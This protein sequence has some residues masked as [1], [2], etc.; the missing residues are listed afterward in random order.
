M[1]VE[2]LS[3]NVI[4]FKSRVE[5]V[6]MANPFQSLNKPSA[7]VVSVEKK[8]AENEEKKGGFS[9]KKA[10]NVAGVLAWVGM[11]GYGIKKLKLFKGNSAERIADKAKG[12][13]K[14]LKANIEDLSSTDEVTEIANKLKEVKSPLKRG[15]MK[16][17]YNMGMGIQKF[18]SKVGSELF[19]NITYAFGTLFVMPAVILFSPFGKKKSTKEDKAFAIARQ[20]LSVAATFGMQLTFDKLTGKYL[21][22]SMKLN[23]FEDKAVLN[24]LDKDGKIKLEDFGKIKLNQDSSKE[25]FKKLFDVDV[26]KG[27]LKGLLTKEEVDKMFDLKSYEKE[28]AKTL[29]KKFNEILEAK[30]YDKLPKKADKLVEIAEKSTLADKDLVKAEL[31]RIT[32]VE[33]LKNKAQSMFDVYSR[34]EMAL[35]KT[36]VACNVLFASLIGCTF[37]NVIYGKTMK[38]VKGHQTKNEQQAQG[39]EVK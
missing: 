31:K 17:F 34:N 28:N 33:L 4:N 9:F 27:G 22:L 13:T 30:G 23:K 5:T 37:L 35:T 6:Q 32:D 8:P 24:N 36:K 20:P 38:A 21:P 39:K 16:A 19:N 18:E 7:D 1:Q 15:V 25:L 11:V 14:Q 10:T 26:E 2:A 29:R 3:A 12:L